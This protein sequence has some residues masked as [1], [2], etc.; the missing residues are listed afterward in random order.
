MFVDDFI[1]GLAGDPHRAE[2]SAQQLWVSRAAL[3]AIHA[4]FPPPDVLDHSGG[5]DSVSVK[6]LKKG[7]AC[8]KLRETLLGF[9]MQGGSGHERTV[10]IPA[11]KFGRYVERLRKALD[12][13]SHWITFS[14][15]QKIHGQMQHV[16]VA[17]PCLRGQMTPLNQQLSRPRSRVGL[18]IKST[19]RATFELFVALLE[20]AQAYPSHITEIVGPDLPHHYGATDAAKVGSG[21]VWLPCTAWIHPVVWRFEWPLDIQRAIQ[22]GEISM[23]DAEFAAYFIAECMIDYLTEHPIPGLSTFL[24]TDNSPTEAIVLRQA[25]RVKSTMPQATLRWLALRQRHNRR[26]P[27]DIR[28]YEGKNNLMADF[29]SRSFEEG[30]PDFDDDAFLTEFAARFPL[31]PQLQSWRLVRPPNAIGSAA[32]LLLRKQVIFSSLEKTS[33]GSSG[34]ALPPALAA[35]LSSPTCKASAGPSVWAESTCSFPLLRPSGRASTTMATLLRERRSR[36]SYRKSPA[37]W[38]S[39]ELETLAA[40]IQDS[41][42]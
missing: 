8:F 13:K 40:R 21:G 33:T 41:T 31:P 35:T 32:I 23:V 1:Q 42:T 19:L 11:D 37:S 2:R 26:G 3:H 24:F 34:V 6:K 7:D 22:R 17:V 18:K 28:H 39:M 5:K 29:A 15:F 4:V 36:I 9:L 38:S 14:E 16:S 30:Y 10:A 20:D 27:Q 25:S 12:Q